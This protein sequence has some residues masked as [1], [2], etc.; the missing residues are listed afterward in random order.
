[1]AS[2][3]QFWI[4]ACVVNGKIVNLQQ[5]SSHIPNLARWEPVDEITLVSKI[6]YTRYQKCISTPQDI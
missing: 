6:L 5:L 4:N 2:S 3:P 1:M